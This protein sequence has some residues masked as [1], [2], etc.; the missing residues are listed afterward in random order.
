MSKVIYNHIVFNH[1][2]QDVQWAIEQ[3]RQRSDEWQLVRV[4]NVDGYNSVAVFSRGK[5]EAEDVIE[6]KS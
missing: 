4:V 1:H 6:D 2:L 5:T 3:A